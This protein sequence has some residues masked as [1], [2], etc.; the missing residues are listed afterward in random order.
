MLVVKE[1]T[2]ESQ[3]HTF[4]LSSVNTAAGK[5]SFA[6]TS[7]TYLGA[8]IDFALESKIFDL[9]AG[10]SVNVHLFKN[11][12]FK[13]KEIVSLRHDGLPKKNQRI[14]YFF[15]L[16][17]LFEQDTLEINQ[18]TFPFAY[19]ALEYIF[20]EGV[21]LQTK[22][23]VYISNHKITDFFD[24][25]TIILVLCN[26]LCNPIINFSIENYLAQFFLKGFITYSKQTKIDAV[27]TTKIVESNY[28]EMIKPNPYGVLRILQPSPLLIA[29][30]FISNLFQNLIQR[31]ND[32]VT[33]FVMLYQIIEICI[34]K[35][36]H[37]RIQSE[38]C[39]QLNTLSGYKLKEF[40]NEISKEK[41]RIN[42]L[43]NTYSIPMKV[44][45]DELKQEILGFFIHVGDPDYTDDTMNADKTLTD[46]F[47]D[48]R[49]NLV[50]N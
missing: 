21:E 22:D 25:D 37:L 6:L 17:A 8:S 29:E 31:N 42:Y 49:N 14:G 33:R 11:T 24:D 19:Y 12:F 3:I 34:S 26:E 16:D 23:V 44:L 38:I 2:S 46:V 32:P 50:H 7:E 4:T 9:P 36:L 40:L 30:N 41:T 20:S 43:F 28:D 45:N 15:R 13:E 47:Y 18:H 10:Y 5:L 35:I 48:Y 27:N 39:N 1:E